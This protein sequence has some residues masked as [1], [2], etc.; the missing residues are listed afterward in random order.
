MI[1]VHATKNIGVTVF[2]GIV[3]IYYF[4]HDIC[5]FYISFS[6]I[7]LA[8]TPSLRSY[9]LDAMMIMHDNICMTCMKNWN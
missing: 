4:C 6:C 1:Y 2:T 7:A 5:L 9:F 3:H 8:T